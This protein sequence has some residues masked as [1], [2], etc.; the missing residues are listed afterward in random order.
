M[1][2]Y[3]VIVIGGGPGD[4]SRLFVALKWVFTLRALKA[5]IPSE[6]LV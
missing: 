2:K 1:S 4:M 6:E 5:E 3:D